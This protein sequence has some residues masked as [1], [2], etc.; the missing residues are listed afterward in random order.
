[1]P[2]PDL[3]HKEDSTKKEFYSFSPAELLREESMRYFPS[4]IVLQNLNLFYTSETVVAS[5]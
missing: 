2:F 3:H 5:P 1:M 4:F